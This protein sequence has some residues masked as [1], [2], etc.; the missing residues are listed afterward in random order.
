[1]LIHYLLGVKVCGVMSR[2]FTAAEVSLHN[3]SDSAW[4]II[5]G[6]V[7]DVTS[8][9]QDHPG[10]TAVLLKECGKDASKKFHMFHSDDVMNRFGESLLIGVVEK[11]DEKGSA[12]G[13]SANA[14]KN[15]NKNAN[16][17]RLEVKPG[18]E[19]SLTWYGFF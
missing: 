7:Y 18:V 14:N 8:F 6:N 3:R 11:G 10:G 16:T 5:D 1:M 2:V 13:A 9:L 12:G 19:E 15:T 4:V 17:S